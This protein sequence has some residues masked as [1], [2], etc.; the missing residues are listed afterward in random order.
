[1]RCPQ[2][3]EIEDEFYPGQPQPTVQNQHV[4][5][6]FR[7]MIYCVPGRGLWH[8]PSD[9]TAYSR[10]SWEEIKDRI[11]SVEGVIYT[12]ALMIPVPLLQDDCAEFVWQ[13][14]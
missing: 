12:Q 4:R 5:S 9:S 1:M 10:T 14:S 2:W 13:L 7:R 11:Q 8:S 6:D 3:K